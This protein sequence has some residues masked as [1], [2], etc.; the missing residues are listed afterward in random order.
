MRR[1]PF[2]LAGLVG[3]ALLVVLIPLY[4]ALQPRG[5]LASG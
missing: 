5:F 2:A 4:D 1:W 3:I